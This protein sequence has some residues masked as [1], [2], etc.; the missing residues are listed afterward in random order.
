[1]TQL[2]L[3]EAGPAVRDRALVVLLSGSLE[4]IVDLV[5]WCPRRDE[6][7]VASA[8]G[9]VRFGRHPIGIT[10]S[11][12]VRWA[13]DAETISGRSPIERQDPA[14]LGSL[15]AERSAPHP[16][17]RD[18]S[19]PH[20]FDHV[21]QLFDHP[22]APDLVVQH[23]SAHFWGDQGG[24]LGEHGSLGVVQARAPFIAAGAGVR[25]AG[26]V[27]DSCRLVDVAPTILELLGCPPPPGKPPGARLVHQDG[28]VLNGVVAE[29][30]RARHVVAFLLDGTNPNV[31]YDLA[32]RGA[33]PNIAGLMDL[34][35]SYRYGAVASLPTVT[36]A[37]HTA[38]LTGSHPGH[39]GILHNAWID[40][41]TGHQV[42]TN[43]P[44]T[45]TTSM[46]WLNPSVETVHDAVH[47]CFPGA[48][49]VSI[50]E[51][52]D[53]GADYSIFHLMRAGEP[54][55]RPPQADGL[56]DATERFVRPSKNYE[57]SSRIDHTAIDQFCGI[58]SG[59]YRGRSWPLP[60]FT[61]VNFTLTDAAFH[62]G[63]P[64][65]EVAAASVRD[66]DARIGR[67][68][69]AVERAGA[70]DDTAFV[71]VAD[72]GM[73]LSNPEVTGDWDVE[74][75]EAGVAV[76]DEGYGFLYLTGS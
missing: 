22:S 18:N 34:G 75:K 67:I 66:T 68:L 58:W 7:E 51:P 63:G 64:Y 29:P 25:P 69:A 50:N 60:T 28:V 48:V 52:C 43:S 12:Q 65:S 30:G 10:D 49:S 70:S 73:E 45:W 24:H 8:E 61:W 56:P 6:Y 13:F 54:I 74:L 16:R 46:N 71:L 1:M 20:A 27:E 35:C 39:H 40:R 55:D 42:V 15:E 33:A 72:H 2:A 53:S 44:S 4:P 31:L 11:G 47:R 23:S 5:A 19:Y 9:H 36:L 14:H 57:V 21:A 32:G 37:N 59:E 62:E 38:I 17:R 41:V 76:R 3:P 26:L